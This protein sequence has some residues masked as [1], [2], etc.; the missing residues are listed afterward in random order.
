MKD[1]GILPLT[2]MNGTETAM[3]LKMTPNGARVL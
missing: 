3:D 2:S 1:A